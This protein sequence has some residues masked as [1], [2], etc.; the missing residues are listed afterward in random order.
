[1]RKPILQTGILLVNLVLCGSLL[2]QVPT[3]RVDTVATYATTTTL[4]G[5]SEAGHLV[6]DQVVIGYSQ[7]FVATLENG[8]VHLPLPEGYLSGLAMDVNS[9]GVVVGT[10]S[11]N[12]FAWDSGEPSLWSPGDG[13]SYEVH[14]LE[15]PATVQALG[16]TMSTS[17][18]QAVAINDA[19]QVVGFTRIQGFIGG[20]TT[21]FSATA[22]PVNLQDLGFQATVRDLN[23]HGIIVGG[24][25]RMDLATGEVTDLGLPGPYSGIPFTDVIGY[26]INDLNEVVA[27]ANLASTVYENYLTYV[28]SDADGWWQTNPAQLPSRFVGFYDNNNLGDVSAS[29]GVLFRD[30]DVLVED[31][32]GLL[33]ASFDSW[34]VGLGFID[35]QRRIATSAINGSQNALVLLTPLVFGDADLDDQVDMADLALV[36]AA[37]G[38]VGTAWADGDFDRSGITDYQDLLLM[39]AR[40]DDPTPLDGLGFDAA[41]L[42]DWQSA[43][44]AQNAADVPVQRSASLS[45]YPNPFNPQTIVRF[46]GLPEG[47]RGSVQVFD[48]RGRL[49]RVLHRGPLTTS[50]YTWDGRDQDGGTVAAGV[51]L[52]EGRYGNERA[53]VKV[54]LAK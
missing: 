1:M 50:S 38:M 35:D 10:V 36:A 29:G 24:G 41:F 54:T 18:G 27:A 31:V 16:Q 22:E 52:V 14:L 21:L 49:V 44:A 51:Y 40:Y 9:A 5:A 28:H 2:A 4:R 33:E 53:L 8:L 37:Y 46:S 3:Y 19:G 42:A 15:Y 30:E 25:L 45:A 7:P 23:S 17:G 6:G 12:G 48:L 47:A 13:G 39:A 11:T 43:L 20:P 26:A 34:Q 32:S